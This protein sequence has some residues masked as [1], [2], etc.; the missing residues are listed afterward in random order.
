MTTVIVLSLLAGAALSLYFSCLALIWASPAVI[1]FAGV[2]EI[3]NGSTVGFAVLSASVGVTALQAAY[4]G[5]AL[6]RHANLSPVPR[7]EDELTAHALRKPPTS[8]LDFQLNA[9][10]P[11]AKL[12][13]APTPRA[14][15]TGSRAG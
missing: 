12:A 3:M 11:A 7:K 13:P 4:L 14:G 15:I 5:G 10:R 2:S 9:S 1:L 6:I 8:F